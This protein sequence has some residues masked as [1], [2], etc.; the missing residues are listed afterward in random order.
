[1][2]RSE[3]TSYMTKSYG[4]SIFIGREVGG[5]GVKVGKV[6]TLCGELHVFAWTSSLP[7]DACGGADDRSQARTIPD[8]GFQSLSIICVKKLSNLLNL[9]YE[10]HRLLENLSPLKVAFA[11]VT[12]DTGSPVTECKRSMKPQVREGVKHTLMYQ[13]QCTE[14][15]GGYRIVILRVLHSYTRAACA[16]YDGI[17]VLNVHTCPSPSFGPEREESLGPPDGILDGGGKTEANIGTL[18]EGRSHIA[19]GDLTLD[20]HPPT[21]IRY[22]PSPLSDDERQP[23]SSASLLVGGTAVWIRNA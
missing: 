14:P 6:D 23:T 2:S 20:S 13:C 10:R 12:S 11:S 1:M 4:Y 21:Q 3:T 5:E 17:V 9:L 18:F 22:K 7:R 16:W 8:E 19:S 15:L